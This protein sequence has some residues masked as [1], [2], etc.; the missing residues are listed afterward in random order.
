VAFASFRVLGTL[1]CAATFVLVSLAPFASATSLAS[2]AGPGVHTPTLH[3]GTW[4]NL[5][6]TL[7]ASPPGL[8][9]GSMVYDQ[10]DGYV[11][12][13]GGL[14]SSSANG[15][16]SNETWTYRGGVW[17]QLHLK[18]HP[19]SQ[20]IEGGMV[21]DSKDG[22]VLL[23][24][25]SSG[26]ETWAFA[27]GKWTELFPTV[28][29]Y[30]RNWESMAYDAKDGYVVLYG[31][32][33]VGSCGC[34]AIW[35]ADTWA[36]SGGAWTELSSYG[37]PGGGKGNGMLGASMTYDPTKGFVV[38]FGGGC[39]GSSSTCG[40]VTWKFSAGK[41][42]R[43]H[44][45]TSPSSRLQASLVFDPALRAVVLYGGYNGS[46]GGNSELNDTWEFAGGTWTHLSL[47]GGPAASLVAGSAMPPEVAYDAHDKYVLMF[48]GHSTTGFS[49]G[50]TNDT[51][52]YS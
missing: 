18:V 10:K 4:T 24:G 28:A 13:F 44:P 17:T 50:Y 11:V 47:A 27:H 46:G 22:Y 2:L 25:G 52:L 42:S 6:P 36:Y 12:L 26:N 21:Y 45:A 32:W 34:Y 1:A 30:A 3:T 41:W 51:W 29:P 23:F 19:A 40:N 37:G 20:E 35:F 49:T 8:T 15:G 48:G 43:L 14:W 7:A 39:W 38:L 33:G 5:T 9:D 16:A 31:G